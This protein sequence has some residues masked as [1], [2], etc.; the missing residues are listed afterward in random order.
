M[1]LGGDVLQGSVLQ[2]LLR[3]SLGLEL[4]DKFCAIMLGADDCSYALLPAVSTRLS[5]KRE[6]RDTATTATS[7]RPDIVSGSA[8]PRAVGNWEMMIQ[9]PRQVRRS[10]SPLIIKV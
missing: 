1:F 8:F 4:G 5:S 10:K 9:V 2:R 7:S 6:G 3:L